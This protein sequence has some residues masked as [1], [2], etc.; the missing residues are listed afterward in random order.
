[1]LNALSLK[2]GWAY[3]SLLLREAVFCGWIDT[4][5]G[6]REGLWMHVADAA[7]L[8]KLYAPRDDVLMI[9]PCDGWV[10]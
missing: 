10:W 1:M 9:E 4:L 7:A 3:F 2:D 6:L 8:P 5:R